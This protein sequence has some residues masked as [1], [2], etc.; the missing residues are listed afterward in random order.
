MGSFFIRD[1]L[2]TVSSCDDSNLKKS[3][4]KFLSLEVKTLFITLHVRIVRIEPR[5]L[6]F[7]L[8]FFL[9]F[10]VSFWAFCLFSVY[11]SLL[12]FR[13]ACNLRPSSGFVNVELKIRPG[14]P[15]PRTSSGSGMF[16]SNQAFLRS[17][18]S[19]RS[20]SSSISCL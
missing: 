10:G 7:V 18:R 5:Y 16:G 2:T 12:A 11:A 14:T 20:S 15:C 17:L 13:S 19:N 8:F 9:S 4:A 1:F 3:K 6:V